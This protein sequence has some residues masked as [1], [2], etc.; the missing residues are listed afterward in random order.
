MGAGKEAV[1]VTLRSETLQS[2]WWV[3]GGW[4]AACGGGAPFLCIGGEVEKLD[5]SDRDRSDVSFTG[6]GFFTLS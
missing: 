4:N 3:A 1:G 2:L 5:C 6:R